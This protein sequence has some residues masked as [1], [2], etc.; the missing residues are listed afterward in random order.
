ML[1][2]DVHYSKNRCYKY[3][4]LRF[5]QTLFSSNF[6]YTFG[7]KGGNWFLNIY[8]E[9][10]WLSCRRYF[11]FFFLPSVGEGRTLWNIL[12]GSQKYFEAIKRAFDI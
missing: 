10:Q 11:V 6:M 1:L 7:S 2:V 3:E 5:Y 9:L 4:I 12:L 8:I